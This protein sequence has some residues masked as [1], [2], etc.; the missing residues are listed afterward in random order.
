MSAV[1]PGK[2]LAPDEVEHSL[3][4][5]TLDQLYLCLRVAVAGLVQPEERLPLLLDDPFLTFD[6]TRRRAALDWLVEVASE[7]QVLLFTCNPEYA[8]M[9]AAADPCCA[10]AIELA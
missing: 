10:E 6:A 3:S 8:E 7:H 4:S 1:A 9:L 5:G 2:T